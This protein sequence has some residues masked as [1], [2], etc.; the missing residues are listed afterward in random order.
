MIDRKPPDF[1]PA[2]AGQEAAKDLQE[3]VESV[4]HVRLNFRGEYNHTFKNHD[5]ILART[6][7]RL[8]LTD[9]ALTSRRPPTA[10]SGRRARQR[11]EQAASPFALLHLRS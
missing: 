8:H 1:W 6:I 9:E 3:Q 5:G 11:T 4:D 7:T 2:A 10:T